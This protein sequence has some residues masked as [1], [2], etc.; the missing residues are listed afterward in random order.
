MFT[1]LNQSDIQ[2]LVDGELGI[3]VIKFMEIVE[4]MGNDN[5]FVDIGVESR[6]SSKILLNNA[7]NKRNQVYGYDPVKAVESSLLE[8]PNYHFIKGDSVENG[9]NWKNGLVSIVFIDSVHIKPQVI[10]ELKYW[11]DLVKEVG[12]IILHDTN[13]VWIDDNG[14]KQYYIHKLTHSCA[15]KKAGNLG[16]GCD[17]YAGIDWETPDCAIREFF[18]IDKLNIENDI[19]KSINGTE[20]LGMTFIYKKKNYD[21]KS[22]ISDEVWFKYEQERESVLKLFVK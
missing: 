12:W 21:Y 6:K 11:W 18:K 5:I 1:N 7:L 4:N 22:D 14:N 2:K 9:K 17:N 20:S 15:G 13:W 8:N 10:S 19:I 3:N 16:T